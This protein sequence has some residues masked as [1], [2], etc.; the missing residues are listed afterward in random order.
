MM[1]LRQMQSFKE[2]KE[3]SIEEQKIHDLPFDVLAHHL[4]GLTKQLGDVS[5]ETAFK[6]IKYRLIHLEI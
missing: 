6:M 2:L 3:S 4:V 5:V 1:N